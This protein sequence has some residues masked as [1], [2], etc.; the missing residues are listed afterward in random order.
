MD[1][2]MESTNTVFAEV[3]HYILKE[4]I[5]NDAEL[6]ERIKRRRQRREH[7]KRVKNREDCHDLVRKLNTVKFNEIF[8]RTGGGEWTDA[9]ERF[10]CVLDQ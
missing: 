1:A 6:V 5:L 9:P 7:V 3:S 8:F 4:E 2:K 10:S